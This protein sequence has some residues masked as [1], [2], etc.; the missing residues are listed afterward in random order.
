[1]II[2]Y[3]KNTNIVIL[4]DSS[5]TSMSDEEK[6][7]YIA[8]FCTL[9]SNYVVADLEIKLLSELTDEEK[10]TLNL[11]LSSDGQERYNNAL[12][13]QKI[14]KTRNGLLKKYDWTVLSDADLTEEEKTAWVTYRQALRDITEQSTFPDSVVWPTKPE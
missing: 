5:I 11:V 8:K 10:I 12:K 6:V 9:N 14:R 3:N 4:C 7:E 2:L 13:A 1:M